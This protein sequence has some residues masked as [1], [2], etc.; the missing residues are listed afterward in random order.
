MHFGWSSPS[1]PILTSGQY[2]FTISPDE[3]SWLAVLLLAGTVVGAFL[4]GS[5]ANILGRKK[6]VLLTAVPLLAGWLM[7][8][9]ATN[10]RVLYAARFIAGL[11]N[12]LCF[13][14]VPMYLGEVSEPDIRGMLSSL[15]TVCISLGILLINIIGNYLPIDTTAYISS[16]FPIVLLLTFIWVP[17]SPT[18]LLQKN[19]IG[20]AK[21]NLILLRGQEEGEKELNRLQEYMKTEP[22][23]KVNIC[24][25][26]KDN[27]NRKALIVAYGLRTIQQICG[28][29]VIV[30]YCKTLFEESKE[31]LSPN[32]ST[33]VYFIVQLCCSFAVTFVV[34]TV[35]RRPLLLVSLV[36]SS[37]TLLVLTIF[38]Y[39]QYKSQV[40]V[41][42]LK[43]IPF[44]CLMLNVVFKSLGVRFVPLLMMGEMFSARIK[45]LAV[46]IGAMY[47]SLLAML[48][49]KLYFIIGEA[50]GM[51]LPFLVFTLL[52]CLSIVFVIFVVPETKGKTLEDIQI[53]LGGK[54][55]N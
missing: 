29:T 36:G 15:G 46:C 2:F 25:L 44:A 48:I 24:D 20:A 4:A 8:A 5:S 53:E 54:T 43:Y 38:M 45:P 16:T 14:T 12:G 23:T 10:V 51:Y 52:G 17:E 19:Q 6:M 40:D 22:D 27:V 55:Q 39:L 41:S 26:V 32:I 11:S 35:G 42:N 3:A 34:D 33:I 49:T 31:V 7:I 50:Y 1:L 47:Y 9:L 21:K 13:S 30:F 18:Y 28:T 37:I